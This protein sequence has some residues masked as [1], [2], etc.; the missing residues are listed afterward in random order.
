MKLS[1]VTPV[2]DDPELIHAM[3]SMPPGVEYIVVLTAAPE[4]VV[5]LVHDF[6]RDHRP[7]MIVREVA[8]AGMSTGV[9]CGVELASHE[10]IVILDSDCT[11]M[12]STL[13]A[14]ADA[15]DRATF[16]RGVT[17]TR[18]NGP[19]SSFSGLGQEELNRVFS[20]KRARL[21][22]PSIAFLKT[23]FLALGG[24]DPTIGGSCDHE[25]A[26]RVEDA[27]Y[28]TA[29]EPRAVVMHTA[30]TFR[31]DVRSHRGYGRGLRALDIKRGGRYG[32]GVCLDRWAP[33]TLWRKLV[34]RGPTS[35]F[36]SLLL[37]GVMLHGYLQRPG[38][39]GTNGP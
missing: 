17:H 20:T 10:K 33:G 23:P 1:V 9:N 39:V 18:R 2:R 22:G 35:L 12:L 5:R 36:R 30:I 29:F 24:Y 21:I 28:E 38:S 3:R 19:W 8:I 4:A 14:Y 15:L 7:D 13:R 27:G 31:I 6:R 26:L 25:F 34:R 11:I 32:L 37:G 16:V